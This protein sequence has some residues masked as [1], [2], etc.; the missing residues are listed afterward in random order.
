MIFIKASLALI[1]GKI[2]TM[3]GRCEEA[4]AIADDKIIKVGKTSEVYEFID[5]ETEVIDLE[6]K[7]VLPD[8]SYHTRGRIWIIFKCSGFEQS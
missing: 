3:D 5:N 1:K 2:Y 6:G 8:S 7:T 4:V